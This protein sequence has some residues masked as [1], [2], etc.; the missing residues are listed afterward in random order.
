MG[1]DQEFQLKNKQ[2]QWEEYTHYRKFNELQ[3]WFERNYAIE[4]CKTY[5]LT[6][7]NS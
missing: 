2:G 6:S 5:C 3:G 1:L 4:T 7:T